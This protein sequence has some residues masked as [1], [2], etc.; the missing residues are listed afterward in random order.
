[1]NSPHR[2]VV[3]C[4]ADGDKVDLENPAHIM[5]ITD[6]RYFRIP[7]EVKGKY[8]FVVTA[9]DRLQNESKGAKCKVNIQ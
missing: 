6:N 3:Y 7:Q 2:F 8:I 9:L 1:M 4:F 5:A